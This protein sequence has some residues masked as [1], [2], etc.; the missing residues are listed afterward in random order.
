MRRAAG[1]GTRSLR[2]RIVNPLLKLL[3][4]GMSA[5]RLALSV[6]IGVV[7]GNIPIFGTSTILC[8]AI[9]LTLRLNLPAIQIVQAAMAPTQLLLI[10]PFVRLGEWL[11]RAP[12]QPIS[13]QA[14]LGLTAQDIGR[15]IVVLR[16]A[17]VHASVAWMLIAPFATYS[18]YK[19]LAPIFRRIAA[20]LLRKRQAEQP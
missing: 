15:T 12:R 2:R 6:A 8:A 3:Q 14:G 10:V 11:L 16:D 9:A 1:V 20:D 4:Q 13:I 5:D 19:L 17:L 7:V 18:I